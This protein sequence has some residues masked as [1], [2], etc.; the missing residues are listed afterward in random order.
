MSRVLHAQNPRHVRVAAQLS[1][2][3]TLRAGKKNY[4]ESVWWTEGECMKESFEF[5]EESN[6][7]SSLYRRFSEALKQYLKSLRETNFVSVIL[8]G[9]FAQNRITER[10]DLDILIVLP[11]GSTQRED[12]REVVVNGVRVQIF[13]STENEL[14]DSF[15]WERKSMTRQRTS[16]VAHGAVVAGDATVGR[17]LIDLA[18]SSLAEPAPVLDLHNAKSMLNFIQNQ[19]PDS[20]NRLYE[21]SK[22]GFLMTWNGMMEKYFNLIHQLESRMLP[23]HNEIDAD[24][25]SID[26]I[27]LGRAFCR[28]LSEE[29][30]GERKRLFFDLSELI[31]KRLETF[32]ELNSARNTNLTSSST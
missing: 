1:V 32:V 8:C 17:K 24:L 11:L 30:L 3:L 28:A 16:L 26:D 15:E 27:E 23:R 7:S 5:M 21:S 10:S 18:A 25:S 4:E 20:M 12:F 29:N 14:F 13:A 31:S 2:R 6:L 22:Y 9:S 19:F